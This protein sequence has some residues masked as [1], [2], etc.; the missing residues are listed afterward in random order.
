[1]SGLLPAGFEALEPFVADWA[2]PDAGARME[3]RQASRIED[4]RECIGHSVVRLRVPHQWSVVGVTAHE[5]D[6]LVA[7]LEVKVRVAVFVVLESR[8]FRHCSLVDLDWIRGGYTDLNV[9]CNS[10]KPRI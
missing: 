10:C 2:L 5:E 3:K 8:A 7:Q 9:R 4:I 6:A 1:M